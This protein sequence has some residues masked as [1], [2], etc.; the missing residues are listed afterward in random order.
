[1]RSDAV[2]G[3][4]DLY[5]LKFLCVYKNSNNRNQNAY[6]YYP[7]HQEKGDR[8]FIWIVGW[9]NKTN[10]SCKNYRDGPGYQFFSTIADG[11]VATAIT[12]ITTGTANIKS[13]DVL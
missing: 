13:I 10:K 3:S 4:A 12:E 6:K 1:M 5:Y 11:K 9:K 7:Y 8:T 2:T